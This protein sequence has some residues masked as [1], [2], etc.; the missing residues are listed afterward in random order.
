MHTAGTEGSRPRFA[1]EWLVAV[2]D[3]LSEGV[4]AI[5][6]HGRLTAANPAAERLL[7]FSI[8][9]RRYAHWSVLPL[10]DLSAADGRPLAEHPIARAL[11]DSEPTPATVV[12]TGGQ[13]RWLELATHIL[14]PVAGAGSGVVVS[15]RDVTDRVEAERDREA[16]L[17]VLR[18]V[19]AMS[20]HDLQQPISVIRGYARLLR[21]DS[22][23][24]DEVAAGLAAI[25]RQTDHLV[26]LVSDLS[27]TAR[28]EA[29]HLVANATSLDLRSVVDDARAGS[30]VADLRIEVPDG[31]RV[32]AD[33]D[34]ARRILTNLLQ[35]AA[36]YGAPPLVVA[37]AVVDGIVRI[38]VT[39]A[40]PGVPAEFEPLLFDR[41]TRAGGRSADGSGMGLAIVRDL[42][43]LNGGD[44]RYQ[45][46]HP[47]GACFV[48]E[49]P[50]DTA[51]PAGHDRGASVARRRAEGGVT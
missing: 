37:A 51:S 48:V 29:G 34:H 7:G 31:I 8:P 41:F 16:A 26:R 50:H 38:T 15:F 14:D 35:N 45:P 18:D 25:D 13:Q 33:P 30:P 23:H 22:A 20:S 49:L 9:E 5:D 42:A 39:D 3:S 44:V 17:R 46:G 19:L 12:A 6:G 28:L 47:R 32:R 21:E 27:L 4:I 11:A 24:P 36:K 10:A 43:T 2:L 40:G 1:E